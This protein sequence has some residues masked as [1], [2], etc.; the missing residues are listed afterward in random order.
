MILQGC[1]VNVGAEHKMIDLAEGECADVSLS[2]R[3]APD[4][5]VGVHAG[6]KRNESHTCSKHTI[7]FWVRYLALV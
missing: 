7:I 6:M 5:K 4:D 2:K 1:E 3:D